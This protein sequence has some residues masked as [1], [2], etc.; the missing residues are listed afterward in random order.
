MPRSLRGSQSREHS[1]RATPGA[2]APPALPVDGPIG[3]APGAPGHPL[4]GDIHQLII[5]HLREG[6]WWSCSHHLASAFPFRTDFFPVPFLFQLDI[7]ISPR[8]TDDGD[9]LAQVQ[10][11]VRGR[12]KLIQS[13][14]KEGFSLFSSRSE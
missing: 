1:R 8:Q 13:D 9:H 4:V 5:Q 14:H 10:G 11:D 3:A 12:P 6:H 2:P 7:M